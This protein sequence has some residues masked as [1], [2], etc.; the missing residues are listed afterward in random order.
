MDCIYEGERSLYIHP[1]EC[2]DCG[3]CEPVCPVEAIYF[4]EDLPDA[5][6]D[7]AR[8]NA[9]FF[10]EIGSPQGAAVRGPL[11]FDAPLVA[12]LPRQEVPARPI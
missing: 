8:A 2:I 3:A 7:Y 5:W 12:S 4:H 10:T 6:T 9:E 1:E 11:P